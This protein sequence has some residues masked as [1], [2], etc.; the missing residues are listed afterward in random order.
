[1]AIL[2]AMYVCVPH[3]YFVTL[4]ARGQYWI[5]WKWT[6]CVTSVTDIC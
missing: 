5:S 4:E 3:A 6:L 2:F 1:M